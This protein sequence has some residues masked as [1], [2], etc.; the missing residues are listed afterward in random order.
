LDRTSQPVANQKV[1]PV[2]ARLL[3]DGQREAENFRLGT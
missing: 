3:L 2:V 1:S